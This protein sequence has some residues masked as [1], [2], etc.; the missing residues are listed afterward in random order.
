MELNPCEANS[1]TVTQGFPNILSNLKLHYHLHKSSPLV[2]ILSQIKTVFIT[3]SCLSTIHFN[4]ILAHTSKSSQWSFSFSISHRS[5]L[6]PIRATCHAHL[7]LLTRSFWLYLAKSTSYEASHY[8]FFSNFL[9]FYL[10]SV[11]IFS[12]APRWKRTDN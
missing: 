8:A 11:Q 5:P 12:S 1:C 9:L 4:T 10:Y 3:P 6:L 7:T 2:P